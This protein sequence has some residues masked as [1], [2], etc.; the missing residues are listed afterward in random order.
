MNEQE[1]KVFIDGILEYFAV[2]DPDSRPEIRSPH[3]IDGI[4]QYVLKYTGV[5]GITG[6]NKGTVMFSAPSSMLAKLMARYGEHQET[7]DMMLD[8]VGEI[9][10]TVSGNAREAFGSSFELAPP[11]AIR[12]AISGVAVAKGLQSYCIPITWRRSTANLIV[13][14]T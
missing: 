2:Y 7:Q 4:D 8:L 9:A 11:V 13:S 10:N 14:L 1:I 12:G 6:R 5:I 3:L